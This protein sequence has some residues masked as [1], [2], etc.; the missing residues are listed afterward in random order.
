MHKSEKCTLKNINFK[1]SIFKHNSFI[2]EHNRQIP[3]KGNKKAT[4]GAAS[5][6]QVGTKQQ[7]AKE[8][9]SETKSATTT[10]IKPLQFGNNS[11]STAK[12]NAKSVEAKKSSASA[13]L[14]SKGRKKIVQG[15]TG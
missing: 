12:K 4:N 14:K 15:S 1:I 7:K 8:K 5:S 9:S 6:V 2:L 3:V 11:K 10:S 13:A